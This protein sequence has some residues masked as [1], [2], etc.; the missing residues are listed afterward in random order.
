MLVAAAHENLAAIAA[1]FHEP[2][3]EPHAASAAADET[4]LDLALDFRRRCGWLLFRCMRGHG[5]Q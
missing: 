5:F 4:D 3:G 1:V 2:I